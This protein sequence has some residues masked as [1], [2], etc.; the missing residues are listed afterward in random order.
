MITAG[1]DNKLNIQGCSS[2]HLSANAQMGQG[3]Y[4]TSTRTFTFISLTNS[5]NYVCDG[6]STPRCH[7]LRGSYTG[8][9]GHT[10]KAGHVLEATCY[11]DGSTTNTNELLFP[12]SI[13]PM[14]T[15][16]GAQY[17]SGV[18]D[19]LGP[20]RLGNEAAD[21]VTIYGSVSTSGNPNVDLSDSTG[22]F[23]VGGTSTFNGPVN[24]GDANADT[25]TIKGHVVTS[26]NPNIDFSG[27]SGT[28]SG[29]FD[30]GGTTCSR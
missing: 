16:G 30:A 17:G 24:L 27:S 6:A 8:H 4:A 18:L 14:L 7:Q 28:C 20:V 26:G 13:F 22:T 25:V 5:A 2:S 3:D 12:N 21:T 10:T 19:T 23:T 9:G 15:V 11:R 1:A 29:G